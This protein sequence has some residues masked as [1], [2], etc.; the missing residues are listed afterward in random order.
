V[1]SGFN[2]WKE[3]KVPKINKKENRVQGS[4]I[5]LISFFSKREP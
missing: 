3:K 5:Q 1:V 2:G 4:E